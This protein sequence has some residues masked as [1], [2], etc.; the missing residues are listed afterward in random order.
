[1]TKREKFIDALVKAKEAGENYRLQSVQM[2]FE[3]VDVLIEL[4]KEQDPVKAERHNK[5]WAVCEEC[6][7]DFRAFMMPEKKAKYCPNCGRRL[8]WVEG[9][10]I[11]GAG[12]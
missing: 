3:F 8:E 5:F 12:A 4:L 11:S 10:H 2:S 6:T 7:T 9:D 1:M